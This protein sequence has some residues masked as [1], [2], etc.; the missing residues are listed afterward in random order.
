MCKYSFQ[1]YNKLFC[2]FNI[3]FLDSTIT[4]SNDGQFSQINSNRAPE[5][6]DINFSSGTGSVEPEVESWAKPEVIRRVGKEFGKDNS[7][8]VLLNSTKPSFYNKL[9][10]ITNFVELIVSRLMV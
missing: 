5:L 3:S 1:K 2:C 9:L 7:L 10:L 6:I 8:Y 4:P